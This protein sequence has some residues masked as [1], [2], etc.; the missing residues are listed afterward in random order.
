MAEVLQELCELPLPTDFIFANG[1]LPSWEKYVKTVNDLDHDCKPVDLEGYEHQVCNPCIRMGRVCTWTRELEIARFHDP[2]MI[3][4]TDGSRVNEEK[5][6]EASDPQLG[7]DL[8]FWD[9]A[10]TENDPES[11]TESIEY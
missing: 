9:M 2:R 3:A 10:G 4:L 6:W 7:K 5:A 8:S 1:K 11:E